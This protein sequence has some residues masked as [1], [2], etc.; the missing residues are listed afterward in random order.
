[1]LLSGHF[2]DTS[3]RILGTTSAISFF[4][5]LAVPAGAVL[6][7]G[8]AVL[9]GRASAALTGASFLATL[10]VIWTDWS[11]GVG[12]TWGVLLTLAAAAAQAAAVESRRRDTDTPV[13]R[14][15]VAVSKRVTSTPRSRSRPLAALL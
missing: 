7:R 11:N 6:E 2:D 9:L 4:G 1:M 10:V 14:R 12:K 3:W 5:L 8:H 15:L 13:I